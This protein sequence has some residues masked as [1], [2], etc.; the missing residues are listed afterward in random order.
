[1]SA[2]ELILELMERGVAV[3]VVNGQIRC[4]HAEGALSPGLAARVRAN[5]EEILAL[6]VD[7]DAF[8]L[9]MAM[10]IFDAEP[11]DAPPAM[12]AGRESTPTVLH[13]DHRSNDDGDADHEQLAL[14]WAREAS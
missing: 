1:M 12:R 9:A 5:R 4:R 13:A 3:D 2:A 10:A 8:R 7:P 14:F 11:I 6:L